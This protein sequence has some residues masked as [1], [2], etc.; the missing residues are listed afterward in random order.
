MSVLPAQ[1]IRAIKPVY[2]FAERTIHRGMTFGLGP[3]GYDVRIAQDTH[4][5]PG[6][7][8][9]ASTVEYFDMPP[10]VLAYVKD[11]SSFARRGLSLF[12]TVI[13][14][15]W[16]G[17]LTL[18]LKNQGDLEFVIEKGA[19][20]AQIVFHRLEAATDQPYDGRYQDQ[21]PGP[22]PARWAR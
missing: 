5:R 3:A 21:G 13:E 17:F 8:K 12:N 11:K 7:F 22:Q 6:E 4:L 20:I 9:L 19:P 2:P 14:P 15:G 16:R 10:D 1:A 18:E